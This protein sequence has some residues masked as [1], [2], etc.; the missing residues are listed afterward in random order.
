MANVINVGEIKEPGMFYS[1]WG[2]DGVKLYVEQH[3]DMMLSLENAKAQGNSCCS[4]QKQKT[5]SFLVQE[6]T[7]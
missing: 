1:L 4:Q 5:K 2:W 6:S 3:S 7:E